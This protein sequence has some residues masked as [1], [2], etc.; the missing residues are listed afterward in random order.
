M[1]NHYNAVNNYDL[2]WKTHCMLKCLNQNIINKMDNNY[3]E[4]LVTK[5]LSQTT[6]DFFNIWGVITYC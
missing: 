3:T 5:K 1:I 6:Y 4:K 2:A